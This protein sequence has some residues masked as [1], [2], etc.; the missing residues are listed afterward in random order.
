MYIALTKE[1]TAP[2]L[3]HMGYLKQLLSVHSILLFE[4]AGGLL[5]AGLARLMLIIK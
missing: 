4:V 5:N 3:R 1:R 2:W